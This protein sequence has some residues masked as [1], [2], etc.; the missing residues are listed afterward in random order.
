MSIAIGQGF[1]LATPLQICNMTATVAN[2]G[3]L[4]RPML[5]EAIYDPEG[6]IIEQ[7]E[8]IIDGKAMGT[9]KSLDLIKKGLIAAVNSKH[10]T[11]GRAKLEEITV[12]GKTG[13]SQ[14]VRLAQYRSV[15]EDKVPYKYRDHAWFTCFAPADKPEIAIAV[16]MEHSGHGGSAAA[17]LAK[18]VLEQYFK[19]KPTDSEVDS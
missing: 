4:Y 18:Q 9:K 12:A 8:P 7:F 16:L 14:V 19:I 6:K 10:G 17:P 11:G 2:G 1:D 13:T 15:P 5:I 3:T